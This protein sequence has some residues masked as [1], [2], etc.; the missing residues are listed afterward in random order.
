[1]TRLSDYYKKEV[2]NSFMTE[3]KYD[4]IYKVPKIEKIVLNMR[5]GEAAIDRKKIDPAIADLTSISGQKPVICL[6]KKAIAGFKLRENMPI[7]CK[8]TLRGKR[9]YE[10]LGR[11]VVMTLPRVKDFKGLNPKSFD[12]KGNFSLGIK[13]QI[14]FYEINYDKIDKIRG[15]DITICTT[16]KTN[17]EGQFLLKAFKLPFIKRH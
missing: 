1:M 12:G 15:L 7:G 16:A 8:V 5:V 6:S 9:M 4:N 2:V 17:E 13:E 3:Y 14:V 10:F 11:L